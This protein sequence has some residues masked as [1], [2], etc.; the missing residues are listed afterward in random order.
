MAPLRVTSG[1]AVPVSRRTLCPAAVALVHP[2]RPGGV[3]FVNR[4]SQLGTESADLVSGFEFE[5]ALVDTLCSVQFMNALSERQ[6]FANLVSDRLGKVDIPEAP[7]PRI[8]VVRIVQTCLRQ[9]D[10]LRVLLDIL[11]FLAPRENATIEVQNL[12]SSAVVLDV[13]PAESCEAVRRLLGRGHSVEVDVAALLYAAAGDAAPASRTPVRTLVEAFDYLATMNARED[14]LPPALALVE[15]AAAR[16]PN[17]VAVDLRRWNDVQARRLGILAQ[18]LGVRDRIAVD[19]LPQPA[20]RC[21]VIQIEPKRMDFGRYVLSHWLQHRPGTWQPER[22]EDEETDAAGLTDAVKRLVD[23]AES[24]WSD[25][26]GDVELE[27]VLPMG[28]LNEAVDW[29]PRD[30]GGLQTVPLCVD[31]PVVLRSLDRMLAVTWHRHWRNRWEVLRTSPTRTHWAPAGEDSDLERWNADLRTDRTLTSVALAA[32]P[33][34]SRLAAEPLEMALR[35]GIP[36]ALW[37]RRPSLPE[38]FSKTVRHVLHGLPT[39]LPERVRAVRGEAVKADRNAAETH[40]GR[41]LAVLWD[42][43]NRLVHFPVNPSPSSLSPSAP[44]PSALTGGSR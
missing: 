27:F 7:S 36:I 33:T 10:G 14:G 16:L 11:N 23:R 25:R 8:H 40:A 2:V 42:D 26:P 28:M 17:E 34:G 9:A 20:P 6:L 37:D 31:Y 22:G 3:T 44:S 15:H 41:H 24:A 1:Q 30:P 4:G 12:V 32:P 5:R 43:P 19:P 21:L 39:E 38:D 29:W 18:L 35:A 13:L